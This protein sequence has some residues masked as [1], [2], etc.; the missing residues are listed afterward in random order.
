[1]ASHNNFQSDNAKYTSKENRSNYNSEFNSTVSAKGENEENQL[2]SNLDKYVDFISWARFYPDLFLDLIKPQKGGIKL[3]SD[4]RTFMRVAMR[5]ISMY[6]VY[7]R[8]WGKTFN[9]EITMFVACV[10]FP[11]IE[12]ALTA[13]TK[14]NAA[15]LLKDKYNDILKKYPWFK[16]EIYDSK[17]SKSDAEI[18]FVNDSRIDVL[19]NS[20]TSKGQRRH[21]IMIEE[22][23]L[24]D[25]FTFQDALYPIVE[26]GRMTVG[27]L[28]ITNPEE[29]SQKV[30]FYTTAGFRGSDEFERSLRIKDDM[31]HLKGKMLMGS[32]WHL[33]CWYGRGST[34][35][36]IL[37]KKK[38]MSPIAFAQN[39]ESKWV[40]SVD[41]SLVDIN[42]LLNLRVLKLPELECPKDKKGGLDLSEY[43][44]GVDV[45][46]SSSQSNN[47]SAIVVL[48]LIRN[49]TNKITQVQLV[50]II[51][52]PNGLNYEEQSVIVKQ[53]FYKYGGNIDLNKSRV[54][55]VVID[56]NTIGQGLVEKL[57]EDVNCPDTDKEL[58]GWDT[59]NTEDKPKSSDA[60]KLI[61]ALK[62]TGIN[63][64]I[65]RTFIDY[66]ESSKLKLLMQYQ[67]MD[68]V[69]I[70]NKNMKNV[71]VEIAC[72][73]TQ[74]FI[75]EVANL[76]IKYVNGNSGNL[77][78]EQ[79]M[80]KVD[81]DI[82]S[83]T[84]YGLWYIN[85]FLDKEEDVSS[86]DI[87]DYCYF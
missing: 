11:G 21:V 4:Q 27:K 62:S 40:G 6:G 18:K 66:V 50:N 37:D 57:M 30:N 9:E 19:A 77:T 33:G 39:Y 61:Y 44:L 5:F 10:L 2:R 38:N 70:N 24:I 69:E 84:A 20:Q 59:I 48:K 46:R 74:M 32:D 25:D 1:M 60:P 28:A 36:Q 87:L 49:K 83:A 85:M 58:K 76:K 56:A 55:A 26:H 42:K 34:K 67:A 12:F 23:A 51:T 72:K 64:D 73:Q 15:E 14:E 47:K 3:H 41:G 16:N 35:Q 71:D 80:R 31:I 53:V 43:V 63:G 52:P 65:I 78:V 68:L 7:P 75:D 86:N 82:Y 54:K 8:G 22:S 81:K 29:P 17:F 13:Q 79:L 45:A